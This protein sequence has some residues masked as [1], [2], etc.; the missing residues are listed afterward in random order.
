MFSLM[1]LMA[2]LM[3]VRRKLTVPQLARQWG[4]APN[5]VLEWIRRGELR[6]INLAS[7]D[8]QRPRWAIDLADIEAFERS[9]EATP[10]VPRVRRK[11]APETKD[12]FPDLQ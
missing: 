8:S 9:R 6:A 3:A 10:A 12:F 11:R 4:V 2:A 1:I 5:K 7:S